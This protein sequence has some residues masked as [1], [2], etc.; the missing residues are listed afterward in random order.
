MKN[1][2]LM[3]NHLPWIYFHKLEFGFILE[4]SLN[5]GWLFW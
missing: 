5:L 1:L 4:A 3:F 2:E